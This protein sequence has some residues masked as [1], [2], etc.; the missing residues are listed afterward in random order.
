VKEELQ[1]LGLHFI[2]VSMSI[3]DI[4][5][6][7]TAEQHEQIRIILHKSGLELLDN[8]KVLLIERMKNLIIEMVY[9]SENLL[10][11]KFSDYLS[12]NLKCNY[13]YLAT[14]FSEGLG[15]TIEEFITFHKIERVKELI[16]FNELSLS[17]IA[18]KMNYSSVSILSGQFK[19]ISGLALSHFK[20]LH[21]RRQ[22]L[23][24]AV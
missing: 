23:I 12:E 22:I 1:K 8:D 10:K 7:I 20:K 21:D 15:T 17:Q 4:M 6:N 14:L 18:R 13:D 9:Y 2:F 11:S 3:V 16:I 5:E 24:E 19:N